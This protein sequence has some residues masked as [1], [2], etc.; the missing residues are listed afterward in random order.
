MND[1][2]LVEKVAV[3]FNARWANESICV[4]CYQL[5]GPCLAP[6]LNDTRFDSD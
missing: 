4:A 6:Y 3:V 2:H 5:L 1:V